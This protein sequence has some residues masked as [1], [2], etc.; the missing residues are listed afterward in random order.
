MNWRQRFAP[1][2]QRVLKANNGKPWLE[3]AATLRDAFPAGERRF[4]PYKVWLSEI[5]RQRGLLKV[6]ATRGVELPSR[7]DEQQPTLF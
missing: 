7:S 1:I 4:W 6:R 3:I 2:I 5:R